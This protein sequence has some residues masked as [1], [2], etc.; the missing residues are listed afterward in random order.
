[1]TTHTNRNIYKEGHLL[2][3]RLPKERHREITP[4]RDLLDAGV[5]VGL[6][7][8]NVPVSMFWPIWQ[9]VAREGLTKERIGPEQAITRPQALRCSTASGAYLT[10]DEGKKA[11]WSPASWR[12]SLS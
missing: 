3:Q 12:T 4:M 1:V 11:H 6:A 2:Q 9:V 8:D 5:K 10:F 7:T